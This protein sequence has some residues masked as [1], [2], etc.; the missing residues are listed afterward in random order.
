M[1]ASP[2]RRFWREPLIRFFAA[3]AALF[4]PYALVGGRAPTDD[5]RILIDR[6]E[7]ETLTAEPRRQVFVNHLH[8]GLPQPTPPWY[9][10]SRLGPATA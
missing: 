10:R 1:N 4:V 6:Y 7:L 2:W 3:G 8:S 9:I 5:R